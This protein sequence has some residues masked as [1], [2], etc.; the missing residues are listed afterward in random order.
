MEVKV[1]EAHQ[2]RQAFTHAP[3]CSAI[4]EAC[5]EKKSSYKESASGKKLVSAFTL[6]EL[7]VVI[8][9]IA[10]LL[11]VLIPALSRARESGRAVVC[12]TNLKQIGL[13]MIMYVENNNNKTMS[14][15]W[16]P[17]GRYWFHELAP[18]LGDNAFQKNALSSPTTINPEKL[19]IAYCPSATQMLPGSNSLNLIQGTAK[20]AWGMAG[21]EGSYGR[22][23]WLYSM[24]V[25]TRDYGKD[26]DNDAV[27][28][29]SYYYLKWN[30][31]KA[32]VPV[33]CDMTW[34][35]AW[36]SDT[37]LLPKG[38]K[39]AI[40][41]VKTGN[42]SNSGLGRICIDRHSM[43]VDISFVDGHVERV[44]LSELWNLQWSK[45]FKKLGTITISK[46]TR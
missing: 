2:K 36:P 6:V 21:S 19:K 42:T 4:E 34:V 15:P 1:T 35:N 30:E 39:A 45:K 7:L 8:S 33:F 37:D 29:K 11:A 25:L 44:K 23:G 24:D 5:P 9:I 31:A 43:Q 3:I 38:A 10:L 32:D 27:S 18:Y 12:S 17:N 46:P 20:N 26:A 22:N 28:H 16:P 13:A 40:V 14:D 41:D